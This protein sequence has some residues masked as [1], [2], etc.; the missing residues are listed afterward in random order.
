MYILSEGVA[1]LVFNDEVTSLQVEVDRLIGLGINKV[2]VLGH[3]GY[4]LDQRIAREVRGVD[5]VVGG[6]SN[7]F[8]YNGNRKY[9]CSNLFF[10][11]CNGM[12]FGCTWQLRCFIHF[13]NSVYDITF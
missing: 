6:H 7:S 13:E 9:T 1:N 3:G 8:L 2:I 10:Y 12:Y 4:L 5:I 11:N